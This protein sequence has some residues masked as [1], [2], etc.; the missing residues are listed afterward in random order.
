MGPPDNLTSFDPPEAPASSPAT[1][2]RTSSEASPPAPH[3]PRKR[4]LAE[5]ASRAEGGNPSV[6][7][8]INMSMW[9]PVSKMDLGFFL[10]VSPPSPTK[11]ASPKTHR[12]THV[13]SQNITPP[14]QKKKKEEKKT[15]LLCVCLPPAPKSKRVRLIGS[16][17]KTRYSVPG[18]GQD[19]TGELPGLRI[20]RLE[21]MA[22][23]GLTR[24]PIAWCWR[25]ASMSDLF[26]AFATL[27]CSLDLRVCCCFWGGK[28]VKYL[29]ECQG[30]RELQKARNN[31]GLCTSPGHRAQHGQRKGHVLLIQLPSSRE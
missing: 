24:Q 13:A 15:C 1:H 10:L 16:K 7:V 8:K 2:S 9:L 22:S 29:L 12:N 21:P 30:T 5:K 6:C 28:G 26:F 23:H 4:N 31:L 3:K 25:H 19:G 17:P 20:G 27:S 14:P 18:P 11:K